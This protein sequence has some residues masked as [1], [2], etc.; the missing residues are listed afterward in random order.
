MAESFGGCLGLRVAAAAPEL[1]ERLAAVVMSLLDLR[2]QLLQ[3]PTWNQQLWA[4]IYARIESSVTRLETLA[5]LA[6]WE[7]TSDSP[8]AAAYRQ[9]TQE[10]ILRVITILGEQ[11]RTLQA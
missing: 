7:E 4:G 6:G 3:K 8:A 10:E 2:L 1:V 11:I 9:S 5:A